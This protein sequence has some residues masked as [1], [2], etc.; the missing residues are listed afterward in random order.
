M[1]DNSH[2]H[3]IAVKE[4]IFIHTYVKGKEILTFQAFQIL[5]QFTFEEIQ[6][7]NKQS[8]RYGIRKNGE[9]LF[10]YYRNKHPNL[11][12]K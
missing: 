2:Y 11:F 5:K 12:D 7:A 8:R 6:S 3:Y 10:E 4:L 9:E 1:S